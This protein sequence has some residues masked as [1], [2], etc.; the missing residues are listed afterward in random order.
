MNLNIKVF[1]QQRKGSQMIPL[2]DTST[3]F[4]DHQLIPSV[5]DAVTI[6]D[7]NEGSEIGLE[8]NSIEHIM[9]VKRIWYRYSSCDVAIIITYKEW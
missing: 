3:F 2:N 1:Y 9:T 4:N 7:S 6:T 8:E 5:G